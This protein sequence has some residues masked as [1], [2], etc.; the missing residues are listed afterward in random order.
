MIEA[1][2]PTDK[3]REELEGALKTVQLNEILSDHKRGS[4]MQ[5]RNEVQ[6]VLM[7]ESEKEYMEWIQE[8][9]EKFAKVFKHTHHIKAIKKQLWDTLK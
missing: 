7:A 4:L 2:K 1:I 5:Y 6:L 8:K 9:W 3:E